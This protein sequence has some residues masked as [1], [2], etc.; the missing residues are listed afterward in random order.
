MYSKHFALVFF[1]VFSVQ[2][3]AQYYKRA[4]LDSLKNVLVKREQIERIKTLLELSEAYT[5]FQLDTAQ[6]YI[7][8][9]KEE[10]IK[11]NYEWAICK[12][13]FIESEVQLRKGNKHI[14]E[15]MSIKKQ[16]ANWFENKHFYKDALI[17]QIGAN[18][19]FMQSSGR[20]K[21][22]NKAELLLKKAQALNEPKVIALAWQ[23]LTNSK[24]YFFQNTA[25]PGSG[26]SAIYYFKLSGD[27]SSVLYYSGVQ[28]LKKTQGKIPKNEVVKLAGVAER[29]QNPLSLILIERLKVYPWC[30]GGNVDSTE[31]YVNRITDLERKYG[32]R[33]IY[34]LTPEFLSS[35]YRYAGDWKKTIESQLVLAEENEKHGVLT[36]LSANLFKIG[37]S[38]YY[39]QKYDLAIGYFLKTLD[40]CEKLENHF[41]VNSVKRF[42][43]DLYAVTGENEKA[44]N[45][46]LEIIDWA[47]LQG[48]IVTV[49]VNK[50]NAYT[51]LGRLYQGEGEYEK[52]RINYE[53]SI[54]ELEEY[55]PKSLDPNIGLLSMYLDMGEIKIADS[56]YHEII[57]T[58]SG[59]YIVGSEELDFQAGRLF[60]ALNDNG[61][62]I[63]SL[64]SYL[65]NENSSP[66]TEERK[67]AQFLLYKAYKSIGEDKEA[68]AAFEIYKE[69]ED[70]LIAEKTIENLQKKL[71]DYEISLKESEIERLEQQK[72]ISDL[73]L[74]RQED[75]LALRNLYITLLI[76]ALGILVGIGYSLFRRFKIKKEKEKQEIKK[77][78]ELAEIKNNLFANISHEFK[79][80]LTLIQVPLKKLQLKATKGDKDTFESIL[81]NTDQLLEMLDELLGVS[82]LQNEKIELHLSTFDL[83]KFL[84]NIKLNFAPLFQK[85]DIE[86][87]WEVQLD[88]NNFYGDENRINIVISNLLK[89]AYSNTPERGWVKCVVILKES[90]NITVSNKGEQIPEKDLVHIF[91]RYFRSAENNY[92]GSGIGL[93]W[94][95]QITELHDGT[96]KVDNSKTEQV[97]FIVNIPIIDKSLEIANLQ[98]GLIREE[99][100]QKND[101]SDDNSPQEFP[102]ILVVEDNIEMQDLLRSVLRE[103]FKLDFAENGK[104]GEEMT[105]E[106]QPDL[107]LSDVMMPVKNGFELLKFLKG[108]FST[109]HIPVVLLTARSDSESL[110]IGLDENADDYIGKPFD[111]N[112]LK[113][114]I[115]NLLRQRTHLHK[116][117]SENPLLYSK[118]IKCTQ[119]DAQFLDQ[120]RKILEKHFS[121][122]DFSVEKFCSELASN[123]TSINNKL[124]A[125]SNQ[126]T[127]SYI[128]NFRLEKA[129]K[130][131]IETNL[132][133]F[134]ISI[135]TGF[136]NSQV[137]NKS[138]KNKFSV[139]PSEYRLKG[140][141]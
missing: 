83:G 19:E 96:I 65:N 73:Q 35:A 27:S 126:T 24:P 123:R 95:K 5:S 79:T 76:F 138:F 48:E 103:E 137:F 12:S 60:S 42:L 67:E 119:L 52:A 32:G 51:S 49:K 101:P 122:G 136:K 59:I 62:A 41:R 121:D 88:T 44:E 129:V 37:E 118:E 34:S 112:E 23:Q 74:V 110:I 94:S 61:K 85:K 14:L 58:F 16:C 26:D 107:V 22:F 92:A 80:P 134:D 17:A 28:L 63:K 84:S 81:K 47:T 6:L 18:V 70:S 71:A 7:D 111:A 75:K 64:R 116:L 55:Y 8:S 125:L 33:N 10:S 69:I 89:N 139:T 99:S 77:Q 39:L 93:A 108:N 87:I 45:L 102:H 127:A 131:L 56:L 91:E 90:L 54:N 11:L 40:L 50:G 21:S 105:I 141:K 82:R 106:L 15:I 97:S 109:S 117:F 130:L 1:L 135:S 86:F 2:T 25:Y 30:M 38:Y 113:A 57:T 140:K 100:E 68:L 128:K 78:A 13:Y 72:E 31:Y 29:W 4:Q 20:S 132:S 115:K 124:K 120:A 36:V 9:A 46:Y 53:N 43:A 114:K 133:I 66:I 104:I 3:N 98:N